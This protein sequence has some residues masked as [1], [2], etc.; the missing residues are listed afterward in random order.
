MVIMEIMPPK[1][2]IVTAIATKQQYLS[3]FTNASWMTQGLS[4][5]LQI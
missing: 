2:Y 3:W 5:V 4:E 1:W